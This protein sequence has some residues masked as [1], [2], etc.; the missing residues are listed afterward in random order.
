MLSTYW[1]FTSVITWSNS[2][3]LARA[4]RSCSRKPP[5]TIGTT[6]SVAAAAV[7]KRGIYEVVRSVKERS[8]RRREVG[9]RRLDNALVGTGCTGLCL[10]GFDLRA[11]D[12][13]SVTGGIEHA[14]ARGAGIA[15]LPRKKRINVRRGRRRRRIGHRQ[16][17]AVTRCATV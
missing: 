12:I 14:A 1:F 3:A 15:A 5:A 4:G 9:A 13:G 2:K 10:G 7:R 6:S 8:R 11:L 17:P 16:D